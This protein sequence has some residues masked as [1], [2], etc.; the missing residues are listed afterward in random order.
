MERLTAVLE[1][2]IAPAEA[3]Q[4][5]LMVLANLASAA[6]DPQVGATRTQLLHCGAAAALIACADAAD[7]V[8]AELACATMQN[9]CADAAW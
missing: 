9:L 3:K 7:R 4:D 5:A 6:V 8:T 1:D 2:R